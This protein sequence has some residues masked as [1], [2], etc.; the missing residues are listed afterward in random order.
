MTD[1]LSREPLVSASPETGQ[2]PL[3]VSAAFAGLV[4]SGSTLVTCLALALAGWFTSA[5]G[6]FGEPR[7]ALRVGADAWLMGLGGHLD[8]GTTSLTIAPLGLTLLCGYVA[9]RLGHWAGVSSPVP[10]DRTLVGGTVLMSA[11]YAMVVV[12]T[13]VLSSV[14]TARPHLAGAVLGALAV[15]TLAGGLGI[16]RGSGRWDRWAEQAPDGFRVALTGAVAAVLLV[17]A[18]AAVTVT[19]ALLVDFGTAANVL[20]RLHA[21]A[22]DATM[23]TVVVAAVVPNAVLL[24]GSYLLGPGFA[25]GTG[26]LVSPTVVTLGPVPA[27]PLLAAL[28]DEGPTAGWTVALVALPALLGALAAALAHRKAP[29]SGWD[30]GAVRGLAGGLLAGLLLACLVRL[31]G[32]A[33]GPGRMADVAAPFTETLPV[34]LAALGLGGLVGGVAMTWRTRRVAARVAA[35]T[36]AL[37]DD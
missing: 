20:S 17:V 24:A 10:D 13:G 28:P 31:A 33:V 4:A 27:F 34:A 7:D 30:R 32:G 18:A 2:R 37:S 3:A 9:F 8:L 6:R 19:V 16:A 23:F 14:E 12:V 22:G 11:V 25:V 36:T 21:D 15:S 1:L 26:T 35:P 29:T 5:G